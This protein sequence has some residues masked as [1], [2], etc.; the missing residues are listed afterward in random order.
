M[1]RRIDYQGS[2]ERPKPA[3][4]SG[5]W[6]LSREAVRL[7]DRLAV[8]RYGVPSV[9]LMENA[10]IGLYERAAAL[11]GDLHTARAVILAGPGNNGGDGFALARHLHN[12]GFE[13]TVLL[14]TEP[15]RY[16][17]DAATNLRIV[18]AM[19]VPLHRLDGVEGAEVLERAA[20]EPVLLVDCLL[21]TGLRDAPR[22][23]IRDV[24][25]HVNRLRSPGVAV[26][27]VDVPSGLDCDTGEPAGGAEGVAI[28]ADA[29][30]TFVA[31]KR[32]FLRLEAQ[33]WTGEITVAGIGAPRE[34]VE[35]LGEFVAD[36]R[37]GAAC[38]SQAEQSEPS[39]TPPAEHGRAEDRGE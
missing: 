21:G 14:T 13:P 19:G 16:A 28:E 38:A 6:V 12:R 10:A 9:V 11:L 29:T 18:Q 17:G 33:R 26:L 23:V 4:Q 39:E 20:D 2:S 37:P 31:L 8:E 24:I 7:V 22:G 27:A 5:G 32:G 1:S 30:V 36:T 15:A 35:E 25:L 3:P 34:L